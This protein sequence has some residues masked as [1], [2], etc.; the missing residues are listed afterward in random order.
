MDTLLLCGK[1]RLLA[2]FSENKTSNS[3]IYALGSM[4]VTQGVQHIIAILKIA[5]RRLCF[6]E[7]GVH[8]FLH[9]SSKHNEKP[10]Y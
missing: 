6:Q 8:T 1:L 4:I 3:L 7:Y 9:S 10:R 2:F 5:F